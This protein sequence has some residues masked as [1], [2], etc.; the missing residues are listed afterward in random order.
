MGGY[1]SGGWNSKGRTTADQAKRLD[2]NYL[3]KSGHLKSGTMSHQYWTCGG[4]PSGDISVQANDGGITLIYRA[5]TNG[6]E[7]Q[8]VRESVTVI[9]EPC[10]F[11]GQRPYFLCPRCGRQIIKLY[12]R[13]RFL[14]RSC[15]NL[16][17]QCQR[18]S[19]IDRTLRKD[20]KLR[21]SI[22]GEPGMAS[23]IPDKPKGM[24][25]RTYNRIIDEIH[26]TEA[27]VG[28]YVHQ[29]FGGW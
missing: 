8:D 28:V 26:K 7:W 14:C 19:A 10:N 3:N 29:R 1:G 18:E 27:L 9:W 25:W 4:E 2:V 5:R 24:H 21:A 15:N 23:P 12:G 17:Y 6:G 16:A 11:G 22:G 13:T 20:W